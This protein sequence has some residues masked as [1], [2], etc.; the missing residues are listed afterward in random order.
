MMSA[1]S[2]F[3]SIFKLR[4][5]VVITLSAL[6]GLAV[7]PGA[8][9]S[10]W[11]VLVLAFAVLV[12]AASSGAFNQYVERDIDG[13]MSRT[14]DRPFVTG[15]ARPGVLWLAIIWGLLAVS[16]L[17]AAW[18]INVWVALYVFLGAFT[19]AVIYTVW[20]KRRTWLNI[21]FGGLSG[22]FAVMAGAAV[23]GPEPA[24]APVALAVA[25]FFW[26]PPHFWSLAAALKEDYQAAGVPMLPVV[27]G[28]KRAGR[29]ILANTVL[30]VAASLVPVYYGLGPIYLIGASIGGAYFIWRSVELARDPT[31]RRAMVNF[32][33][34]LVQLSLMLAAA[35]LD[36][37]L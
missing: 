27:V 2:Q 3:L 17:A 33:A 32:F 10:A 23:M 1:A 7:A 12:S 5:G 24:G 14:Q 15:V 18:A 16:V 21:V 11:Q 31:P 28:P 30:L 34:S 29:I 13:H 22:S 9:P 36:G 25:L 26:T 6:A 8:A 20:L 19:Y 4:I 35:M 37:W